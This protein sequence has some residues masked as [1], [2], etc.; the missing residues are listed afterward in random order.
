M[1]QVSLPGRLNCSAMLRWLLALSG[2]LGLP[3]PIEKR[4]TT[5]TGWPLKADDTDS[6]R[7]SAFA[8]EFSHRTK[9]LGARSPVALIFAACALEGINHPG[10]DRPGPLRGAASAA[11]ARAT[12]EKTARC[13]KE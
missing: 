9:A 12:A 7:P 3:P 8:D 4:A 2:A 5:G 13:A 1:S 10:W 6:A 11:A